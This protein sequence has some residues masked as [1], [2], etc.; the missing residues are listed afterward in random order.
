MPYFRHF[1]NSPL[2][3]LSSAQATHIGTKNTVYSCKM[4]QT[5]LA[6]SE[7]GLYGQDAH[8]SLIQA[9]WLGKLRRATFSQFSIK[10][11]RLKS[12]RR[13]ST[14]YGG[15][16]SPSIIYRKFILVPLKNWP[17]S[18]SF[19]VR[20]AFLFVLPAA[21]PSLYELWR[22]AYASISY[23]SLLRNHLKK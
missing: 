4:N 3:L 17:A 18:R 14:S 9:F 8:A 20:I 19:S 16:L 13:R 15:Q 7:V 23:Q 10:V 11:I 6:L 21:Q 5:N 2:K 22:A 12:L 1:C